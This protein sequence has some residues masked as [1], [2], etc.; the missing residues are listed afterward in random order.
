[1]MLS[2]SYCRYQVVTVDTR[3]GI[4]WDVTETCTMNRFDSPAPG[5]HAEGFALRNFINHDS[6]FNCVVLL[7][8]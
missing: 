4:G 7:G 2:V 8:F 3:A 6:T 5:L 1:M